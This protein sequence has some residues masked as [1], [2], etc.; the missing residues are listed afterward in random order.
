V[1]TGIQ[2]RRGREV[3]QVVDAHAG[4]ISLQTNLLPGTGDLLVA[5]A[6]DAFPA[7]HR[8]HEVMSWD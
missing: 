8:E 7:D 1:G 2:H 3:T 4:D 5:R 6:F